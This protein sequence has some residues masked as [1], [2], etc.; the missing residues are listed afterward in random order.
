M[1]CL[2]VVTLS[3]LSW[4]IPPEP[5]PNCHQVVSVIRQMSRPIREGVSKGEEDRRRPL[6]LRAG[7]PPNGHKAVWGV[8]GGSDLVGSD[9]LN[10]P[11]V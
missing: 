1:V 8:F 4:R 5:G 3:S 7:H 6:A 2:T 11:K 9:P 10:K